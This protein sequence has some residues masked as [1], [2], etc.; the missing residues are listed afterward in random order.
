MEQSTL[1]DDEKFKYAEGL[2]PKYSIGRGPKGMCCRD[3]DNLRRKE[4]HDK[5]YYKCFLIGDTN[6]TGTD[7]RLK[8]PA[9][10]YFKETP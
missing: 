3:C 8:W 2:N 4:Y 6:G 10:F 5:T 1:F 9:C 7:I